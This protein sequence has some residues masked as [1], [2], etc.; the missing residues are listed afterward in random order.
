MMTGIVLEV[1]ATS[2]LKKAEM[3]EHIHNSMFQ[4]WRSW[5]AVGKEDSILDHCFALVD[6]RGKQEKKWEEK[7][8]WLHS[9]SGNLDI[10]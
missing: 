6:Q 8:A 4:D 7:K 10:A 9:I 3:I 2:Q 5:A 1:E